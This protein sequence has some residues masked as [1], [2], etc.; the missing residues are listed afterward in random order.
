[1]FYSLYASLPWAKRVCT[2]VYAYPTCVYVLKHLKK[3]NLLNFRQRSQVSPVDYLLVLVAQLFPMNSQLKNYFGRSIKRLQ[4]KGLKEERRE[5][6]IT[7]WRLSLIRFEDPCASNTSPITRN[8]CFLELWCL[9]ISWYI[10][11]RV[12]EGACWRLEIGWIWR[13]VTLGACKRKTQVKSFL[14]MYFICL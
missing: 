3:L 8:P 10:L 2:W 6:K 11:E 9:S 12:M 13:T 14:F 1:M 7:L 4:W 5:R